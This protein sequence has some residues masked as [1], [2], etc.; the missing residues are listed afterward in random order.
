[1]RWRALDAPVQFECILCTL[2]L[3]ATRTRGLTRISR[4]RGAI[5]RE[6]SP[7][8]LTHAA[9]TICL[10]ILVLFLFGPQLENVL[11]HDAACMVYLAYYRR[12]NEAPRGYVRRELSP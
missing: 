2:A 10:T 7:I 9:S 3:K 8:V 1:M 11:S 5:G 6:G 12:R 4:S